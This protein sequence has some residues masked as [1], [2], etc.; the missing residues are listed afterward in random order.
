MPSS[1]VQ[2]RAPR[3]SCRSG[4]SR[5]LEREVFPRCG[6]PMKTDR[7]NAS[8]RS[9]AGQRGHAPAARR[10]TGREERER[11]CDNE[12]ARFA[13]QSAVKPP[14]VAAPREIGPNVHAS[15]T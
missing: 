12:G 2:T 13:A 14:S 9:A 1:S 3:A 7:V 15:V 8:P 11:R 6:P 10:R 5:Y 4:E